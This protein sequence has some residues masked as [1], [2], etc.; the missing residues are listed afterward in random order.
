MPFYDFACERCAQQFTLRRK[1]A[2]AEAPAACPKCGEEARRQMSIFYATNTGSSTAA[3]S[4]P[5]TRIRHI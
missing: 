5:S 4:S 3:A 1:F 2:E